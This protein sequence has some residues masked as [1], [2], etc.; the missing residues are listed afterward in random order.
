[1]HSK[2]CALVRQL[3]W[4]RSWSSCALRS[5]AVDWSGARRGASRKIRLAEVR[6]GRL[7]R[8]EGGRNREAVVAH[9]AELVSE[10]SGTVVGLDFAFGLPAWFARR[11][12]AESAGEVWSLVTR[13]GERWLRD[14]PAPFWGLPGSHRPDL[15]RGLSHFRRTEGES[16]P[17]GG[18]YPKSVFQIGGAGAVGTGSLRGM[19]F[20]EELRSSGYSIPPFDE[21]RLPML[22]EI[23]PRFLTGRINKRDDVARSAWL[24]HRFFDEDP[25]L[26]RAAA[27]T[28][29][30]FDAA[31]SAL[32]I[33]RHID[34]ESLPVA[35]D[36]FDRLE[37]RI[38]RPR[39]DPWTRG[40]RA[41]MIESPALRLP[42]PAR[43]LP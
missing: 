27:E 16:P 20:L 1:M 10:Y 33:A 17:I 37:G 14:S 30:S 23:W 31:A 3:S 35:R 22:F 13:E 9:L 6:D 41:A 25:S 7:V 26:L 40:E 19:P 12:G 29:D 18:I 28:E 5:I 42:G 2:S 4:R 38:W 34:P 8:V 39:L 15:P 32:A 24:Q 11:H 43:F 21:P 36:E